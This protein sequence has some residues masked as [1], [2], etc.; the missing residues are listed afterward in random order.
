MAV[1]A[2]IVTGSFDKPIHDET[3]S[4]PFRTEIL[5]GDGLPIVVP[6]NSE[7]WQRKFP[8]GLTVPSEYHGRAFDIEINTGEDGEE[9]HP[10]QA[11]FG[12][13]QGNWYTRF[14]IKGNR[15][16]DPAGRLTGLGK[17]GYDTNGMFDATYLERSIKTSEIFRRAGIDTEWIVYAARPNQFSVPD[18][19]GPATMR[20]VKD[21]AS[22]NI[23]AVAEGINPKM[24]ESLAFDLM[25]YACVVRAVKTSVRLADIVY[26][27]KEIL[28]DAI[29]LHNF[30]MERMGDQADLPKV[31]TE[32]DDR[33]KIYFSSILPRRFAKNVGKM[34]DIGVNHNY[35][36]PGNVTI[37]G[38]IVDL[39]SPEGSVIFPED[40]DASLADRIRDLD[41]LFRG[42]VIQKLTQ[43]LFGGDGITTDEVD[44][45]TSTFSENFVKEY[46]KTRGLRPDTWEAYLVTSVSYI[47]TEKPRNLFAQ[48]APPILTKNYF[49]TA[50]ETLIT[51]L[52]IPEFGEENGADAEQG[53]RAI[54]TRLQNQLIDVLDST[55]HTW[56][57]QIRAQCADEGLKEEDA[58]FIIKRM[59][60]EAFPT[61]M[62]NFASTIRSIVESVGEDLDE[63]VS[64]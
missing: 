47:D 19:Q 52:A 58:E 48:I 38:G 46:L 28:D 18:K 31:P 9:P 21:Y 56:E 13:P 39:D 37:L 6:R 33:P 8:L 17:S 54:G 22:G 51:Y 2:Q 7:G 40:E 43:S 14:N 23:E 41:V 49:S 11:I 30:D 5:F 29:K 24:P 10:L 12:D 59:P 63:E 3:A 26:N 64:N 55:R 50:E 35:L 1:E 34:Q 15:F 42:E 53:F 25:D 57:P 16:V 62:C 36:N 4:L 32:Q 44:A 45:L 20:D 61:Y 27:D 60:Q